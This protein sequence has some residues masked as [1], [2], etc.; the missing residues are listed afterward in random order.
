MR[1]KKK[2]EAKRG[3]RQNKSDWNRALIKKSS[4]KRREV[5]DGTKKKKF[6]FENS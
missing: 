3:I 4:E 1:T 2:A 6:L 5:C